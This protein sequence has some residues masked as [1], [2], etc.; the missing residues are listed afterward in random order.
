MLLALPYLHLRAPAPPLQLPQ[1]PGLPLPLAH[2]MLLALPYLHLWA[3]A[4]PTLAL[5][6]LQLPTLS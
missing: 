4:P 2:P 5:P 3:P 1:P 6:P